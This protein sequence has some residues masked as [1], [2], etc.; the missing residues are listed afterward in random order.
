[1]PWN[2]R[3]P[4]TYQPAARQP[5]KAVAAIPLL[6]AALAV[7]IAAA[8]WFRPQ[9]AEDTLTPSGEQSTY[10]AQEIDSAKTEVCDARSLVAR[11][12]QNAGNQT[13]EDLTVAFIIAV[14]VRL[15]A[16]VRSGSLIE[17]L[18]D[19]PA[20]PAELSQAVEALANAYQETTPLHLSDAPQSELDQ[21]Y[22]KLDA[23]GAESTTPAV[24]D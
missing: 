24:T 6:L 11:A 16:T 10:T 19:H 14:N 17:I 9:T 13:S 20:V 23:A 1:M 8:S 7:V 3:P 4:N 21:V 2:T 18:Q 15:G 22:K 5:S 12:T